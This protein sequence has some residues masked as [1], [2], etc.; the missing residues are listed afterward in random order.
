VA[1]HPLD[2]AVWW[3]LST[4]HREFARVHGKAIRYQSSVSVFAAVEEW[5]AQAWE[6]LSQLVG[7]SLRCVLFR[8]EV[9][10]VLPAGWTAERRGRGRQ[11]VLEGEL[12]GEA[13]LFEIKRLTG[14]DV[15]QMTAL[16]EL[17]NPGPFRP[18]TVELGRYYGHF[19]GGRLVAMA[20]ERL[21]PDGH[22]EISAVCT[23]PDAQ[24]RGLGSALTRAVAAGILEQGLV[25]F[26]HVADMNEGAR[27]VYERLGFIQ[28]RLVDV[29][30]AQAPGA[31]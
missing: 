22:T 18:R 24:G 8:D 5:D 1:R 14:V 29:V 11:L 23:H 26:L 12:Q 25:P 28:R 10:D 30:V 4:R 27:R 6:D 15:P 19:D 20:G 31:T 7:P 17:T 13:G 21:S 16:V 3:S 9:P 2:N